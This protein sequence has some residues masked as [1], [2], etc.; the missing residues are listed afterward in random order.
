MPVFESL[1]PGGKE[2]LGLSQLKSK[3]SFT[4]GV[5]NSKIQNLENDPASLCFGSKKYFVKVTVHM[6]YQ[7]RL[8][9]IY[10]NLLGWFCDDKRRSGL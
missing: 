7:H 10:S 9:I 4:S 1:I 3:V 2:C 6:N 8:L 5:G